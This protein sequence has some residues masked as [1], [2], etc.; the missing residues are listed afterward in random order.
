MQGLSQTFI[1]VYV[2]NGLCAVICAILFF[3]W[4][5]VTGSVNCVRYS[6]LV[7]VWTGSGVVMSVMCAPVTSQS[8]TETE[9]PWDCA[10]QA[11]A[12]AAPIFNM[13][14]LCMTPHCLRCQAECGSCGRN[15]SHFF[16]SFYYI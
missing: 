4:V 13:A 10:K 12:P 5:T 7:I 11:C 2:N 6:D 9:A 15:T 8:F 1:V 3:S 16:F 14:T